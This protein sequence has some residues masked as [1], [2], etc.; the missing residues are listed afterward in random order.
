MSIYFLK[1]IIVGI[2]I[3]LMSIRESFWL[4]ISV[5]KNMKWGRNDYRYFFSK[6]S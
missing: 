3:L 1:G 2:V 5:L 6:S 4:F